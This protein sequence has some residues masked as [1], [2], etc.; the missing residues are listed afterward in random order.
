MAAEK[1]YLGV[2]YWRKTNQDYWGNQCSGYWQY[3]SAS[4]GYCF[5]DTQL[6]IKKMIKSEIEERKARH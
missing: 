1:T 3:Y 6:G 2:A 4:K 5:A